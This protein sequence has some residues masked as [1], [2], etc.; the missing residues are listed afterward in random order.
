MVI[1]CVSAFRLRPDPASY[2]SLYVFLVERP[3]ALTKVARKKCFTN[4]FFSISSN[5]I[6][7]F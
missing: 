4:V 5:S 6:I 1:V 7:E 2:L 3:L